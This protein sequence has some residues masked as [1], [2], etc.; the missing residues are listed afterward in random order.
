MTT[1]TSTSNIYDTMIDSITGMIDS[2]KSMNIVEPLK[3][4]LQQRAS[5]NI[6]DP[7]TIS[8][9]KANLLK[10][11]FVFIVILILSIIIYYIS[12]GKEINSKIYY[13]V[14]LILTIIFVVGK[15]FM[16]PS[17]KSSYEP[18]IRG[19][20]YLFAGFIAIQLLIY[21]TSSLS[22][23]MMT[24]YIVYLLIFLIII[25]GLALVY[26]LFSNYLKQQTGYSGLFI[27]FIFYLPC[28]FA[29]FVNY[30]K[31]EWNMTPHITFILL[32]LE[33]AFI[34]IYSILPT[35]IDKM[36]KMNSNVLL[37][38]PVELHL[39]RTIAG[40]K[41]FLVKNLEEIDESGRESLENKWK[42]WYNQFV[43]KD[44]LQESQLYKSQL[45]PTYRDNNYS[46]SFWTYVNTGGISDQGYIKESNIFN[47]AGGKPRITYM[48]NGQHKGNVYKVYYSNT[49]NVPPFEIE[50]SNGNQKWNY[51]VITYQDN[52]VNIFINGKLVRSATFNKDNLPLK[53]KESDTIVVGQE[54]GVRGA[55]CNVSYYPYALNMREISASYNILRFNNPPKLL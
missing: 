7:T 47:Y 10:T 32:I 17:E 13:Y 50:L 26:L 3:E 21:M 31:K 34:G 11:G 54:N 14:F 25:T 35:I 15:Q 43:N 39:E 12:T 33:I 30:L 5:I 49:A 16:F 24:N 37:H 1:S 44:K 53:G 19:A 38:D 41:H 29:D 45:E 48:N 27:R 23:I 2:L 8:L 18:F 46:I 28:L 4:S 42:K 51:F 22:N 6:D 52:S 20:I 40:S 36:S 55:I 9:L